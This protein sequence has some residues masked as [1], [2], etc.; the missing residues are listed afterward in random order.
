MRQTT[1]IKQM[2]TNTT[3]NVIQN[4]PGVEMTFKTVKKDE[5][6]VS[7]NQLKILFVHIFKIFFA[8]RPTTEMLHPMAIKVC[9]RL[10]QGACEILSKTRSIRSKISTAVLR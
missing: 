3:A 6:T 8:C 4:P 5:T 10:V 7:K 2:G 9:R 1:G